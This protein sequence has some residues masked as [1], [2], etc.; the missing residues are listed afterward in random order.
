[1]VY[2]EKL[3]TIYEQKN[4]LKIIGQIKEALY[5][6]DILVYKQ[7][8]VNKEKKIIKYE[9]LARMHYGK[10]ILPPYIFL[11]IAKKTKYYTQITQCV[12]Q[13]TFETFKHKKEC[14]SINLIAQ[15]ILNDD[16]INYIKQ[17]LN[18]CEDKT[19]VIFELVES[20]D[21][22]NIPEVAEFIKYIQ[23]TG[24][25]IAID[26]FGTGYSNFSYMMHLHPNYLKI[27]GS[28]IKNLDTNKDALKIVKTII[29]FSKELN[30]ITVAEFVH[31]K[32]IFDI[33]KDLGIDEFQG[34]YFG[35]P[36]AEI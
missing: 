22:Y 16:T 3:D 27:D 24:A 13:K 12:V 35:E 32:Q 34:Y 29:A 11:E 21:L 23:S 4:K 30:I 33:C 1:M 19:K 15:D 2:S 9:A 8:I 31:S 14:F 6:D 7:P 28:L 17:Q 36:I 25:K 18:Q 5:N 10:E 26:D 20:E